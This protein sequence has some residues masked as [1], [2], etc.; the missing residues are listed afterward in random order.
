[1]AEN[2]MVLNEE[3]WKR[4]NPEDRDWIIYN[5]LIDYEGRI[6]KIEG[7]NLLHKTTAFLGGVVGGMIGFFSS[8]FFHG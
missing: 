7:G 5:T 6:K 2:K 8:K 3:S 1:M 4:L